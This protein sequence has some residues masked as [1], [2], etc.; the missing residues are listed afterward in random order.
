MK[1]LTQLIIE[2]MSTINE[3]SYFDNCDFEERKF[4]YQYTSN[5][6]NKE[7]I[8]SILESDDNT[9]Y[10]FKVNDDVIS[11]DKSVLSICKDVDECGIAIAKQSIK[12]NDGE[13]VMSLIDEYEEYL[14]DHLV[15]TKELNFVPISEDDCNW[16]FSLFA[17]A[18][19]STNR[20][21]IYDVEE[22]EVDQILSMIES[23]DADELYD[24]FEEYEPINY[25]ER[26]N[27]W[28]DDD[29]E[30]LSYEVND[31]DGNKVGNGKL[32]VYERNVYI[33]PEY[34]D[35]KIDKE[36][37]KY[38]LVQREEVKRSYS[39][40]EIPKGFNVNNIRFIESSPFH[41]YK[42]PYDLFGDTVTNIYSFRYNGRFFDESDSGDFGTWGTLNY[43]L[44]KWNE[45]KESYEIVAGF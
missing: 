13:V 12:D 39:E 44:Y 26:I 38:L 16:K 6:T 33:Y 42:T 45:E 1:S 9:S 15:L 11:I 20:Y 18:G 30:R 14:I 27:L 43:S 41:P 7:V 22:D 37:K 8:V 4:I 36:P 40:F 2:S 32:S 17:N 35:Y 25:Y 23:E 31:M 21:E 10:R 34:L 3:F 24:Y 28:G 19:M 29:R 5:G